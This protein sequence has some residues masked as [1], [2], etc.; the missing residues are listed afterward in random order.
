MRLKVSSGKWRPFCLSLNVLTSYDLWSTGINFL[1]YFRSRKC[2]WKYHL[3]FALC[4]IQCLWVWN[5][6]DVMKTDRLSGFQL[7]NCYR[8]SDE[9]W[10]NGKQMIWYH[11]QLDVWWCWQTT[12]ATIRLWHTEIHGW[13]LIMVFVFQKCDYQQSLEYI[14]YAHL[15]SISVKYWN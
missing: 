9:E 3:P 15:F 5:G 13:V 8:M 14:S 6:C 1:Y 2:I 11:S 7:H 12:T 4:K 10:C